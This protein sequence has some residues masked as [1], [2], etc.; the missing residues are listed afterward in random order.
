[1]DY[2]HLSKAQIITFT[3]AQSFDKNTEVNIYQML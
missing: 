3:R 2:G 1:M